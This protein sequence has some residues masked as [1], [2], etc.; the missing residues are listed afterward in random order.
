MINDFS[1]KHPRIAIQAA[2]AARE[3]AAHHQKGLHRKLYMTNTPKI[4]PHCRPP[5]SPCSAGT[6]PL[7][8]NLVKEPLTSGIA[9][10]QWWLDSGYYDRDCD[11]GPLPGVGDDMTGCILGLTSPAIEPRVHGPDSTREGLT[12]LLE[13]T[14]PSTIHHSVSH[15]QPQPSPP[16]TCALSPS[17]D[18]LTSSSSASASYEKRSSESTTSSPATN[19]SKL[20]CDFCGEP[21]NDVDSLCTHLISYHAASKPFHCGRATCVTHHELRSLKR[22][23]KTIHLRALY[24]CRCGHSG[25]KDKHCDHLKRDNC[26]GRSPYRLWKTEE[27]KTEETTGEQRTN[28]S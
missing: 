5:L 20:N 23:L 10:E 27:G 18:E 26:T 7:S 13:T 2:V 28:L 19:V 17:S 16:S 11:P 3:A 8:S 22:H 4:N 15:L 6:S 25:R 14:D 24:I 9:D 12:L 21:F 1:H